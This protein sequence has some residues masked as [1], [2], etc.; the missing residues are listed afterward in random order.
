MYNFG[1]LIRDLET[2]AD[3][4]WSALQDAIQS[5][6]WANNQAILHPFTVHVKE[7]HLQ[8]LLVV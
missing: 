7:Q 5:I 8:T 3:L 2:L 1:K 6:H 4:S